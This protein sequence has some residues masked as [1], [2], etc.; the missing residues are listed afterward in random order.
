[1][2]VMQN[3][4]TFRTVCLFSFFLLLA[5]YSNHF[6]NSFHF[7]DDH[8]IENNLYI[9]SLKNVPTFFTDARAFSSLPANSVYRPLVTLSLALDYWLAGG[10]DPWQFH[11]SQF[12]MLVSLSVMLVFFFL[13]ILDMAEEHW[14]NRYVALLIALLFSIHTANT[15][16]VN[17]I[18]SRSELLSTLGVVGSFLVY[19]YLPHWRRAYLYL[20]PMSIGALA[21]SPAV[22]FAPLFFVYLLL[23]EKQLAIPDLFSRRSWQAVREAVWASLPAF[24]MG[25]ALFKFTESMNA[26]SAIYGGGDRFHYL[27]T[28]IFMW[29][30]YGRLFLFPIGLSADTD[31]Q[32]ISDWYD[33]RVAAGVLFT[34]LLLRILWG[35]S[36]TT[37]LRP[38]AF[39]IA[40]FLLALLPASSLFPLAEV[41]ND[42]RFFFP[43]I[44]LSLAVV[45]WLALQTQRWYETQSQL[46]PFVVPAACTVALLVLCGHAIGTYQRNK[47]WLSEETLWR[48]VVEKSPTNGRAWMNY[49]L[50][51]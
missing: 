37:A 15:Q 14:W 12:L 41:T 5:A 20:L 13:R 39:G 43:Y 50:A 35:A 30:H 48:D 26:P 38:V 2:K 8:V 17:Y 22:M 31:F 28:Q 42:H 9:R 10:L 47:A 49:S 11:L 33:S 40:W 23:F 27:L 6:H 1:M 16:T 19:F 24:I 29:L 51:Q 44:G 25:G 46:R 21:K 32:L 45:W 3:K 18:S 34:A 4:W 36:R 7:D